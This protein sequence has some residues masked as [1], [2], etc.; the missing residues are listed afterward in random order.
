MSFVYIYIHTQQIIHII[1]QLKYIKAQWQE[2]NSQL[3]QLKKK[4][5]VKIRHGCDSRLSPSQEAPQPAHTACDSSW[6][7][8]DRVAGQIK[9]PPGYGG[10]GLGGRR[11]RRIR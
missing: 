3:E 10:V 7:K 6:G 2:N 9:S 4:P 8:F 11:I 5:R 1:E